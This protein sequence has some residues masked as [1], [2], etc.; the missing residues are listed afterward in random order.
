MWER[1]GGENIFIELRN[2]APANV[3]GA[4]RSE[5]LRA[6]GA[7]KKCRGEQ[8]PYVTRRENTSPR[9]G[10][11]GRGTCSGE[12]VHHVLPSRG[13]IMR[14]KRRG[15]GRNSQ[16]SGVMPKQESI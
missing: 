2:W 7:K 16:G 9:S 8:L 6:E 15:I 3:R 5:T 14:E 13:K 11:K 12:R 10:V 4:S 1:L